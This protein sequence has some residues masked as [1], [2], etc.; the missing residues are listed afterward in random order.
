MKKITQNSF[1]KGMNM[2]LNPLSTPKDV[3]TDCLNGT[4]ITYNGD[5]FNLQTELG[6]VQVRVTGA[7]TEDPDALPQGF[8]PLGI[9]EYNGIMYIVAHNPF[10][11]E[12]RVGS[13]PSP[14]R[15]V[16]VSDGDNL[17][18]KTIADLW[19]D[20][21]GLKQSISINHGM[22]LL[23]SFITSG[24]KFRIAL[25]LDGLTWA[26]A[27]ELLT[28]FVN[29]YAP[30]SV[31]GKDRGTGYFNFNYYVMDIDGNL[32]PIPLSL[33]PNFTGD[34]SDIDFTPSPGL[35]GINGV[36]KV[37]KD[38]AKAVIVVIMTPCTL[39]AFDFTLAGDNTGNILKSKIIF[40]K[41]SII[42]N[43]AI[44]VKTIKIK[45]TSSEGTTIADKYFDYEAYQNGT[46]EVIITK[47]DVPNTAVSFTA[48]TVLT[49]TCTPIDQ[50]G[51]ELIDLTVTKT[52]EISSLPLGIDA[53]SH[54]TYVLND[55]DTITIKYNFLYKG[56]VGIVNTNIEFYDFW[57]NIST[58]KMDIPIVDGECSVTL[59]LSA[60][61]AS[62]IFDGTTQGGYPTSGIET[63]VSTQKIMAS[64]NRKTRTTILRKNH[65]YL[66]R[67]FG[68]ETV[69]YNIFQLLYTLPIPKF[70][71]TNAKNFGSI[72]IVQGLLQNGNYD[73]DFVGT[74]LADSTQ[75]L[76]TLTNTPV[77]TANT[78]NYNPIS[79]DPTDAYRLYGGP[80]FNEYY[81]PSTEAL[82]K[83]NW[84]YVDSYYRNPYDG[85]FYNGLDSVITNIGYHNFSEISM[86][87]GFTNSNVTF[88]PTLFPAGNAYLS[89]PLSTGGSPK[90]FKF[91]L[92]S[93]C[94]IT[95]ANQTG[96]IKLIPYSK[97]N[98][99]T[100]LLFGEV[101]HTLFKKSIQ[102]KGN[103]INFT[104]NIFDKDFTY[105]NF[106]DI[107]TN[108]TWL[109]GGVDN[110]ASTSAT[111]KASLTTTDILDTVTLSNITLASQR[112]TTAPSLFSSYN[113]TFARN[114]NFRYFT[115][116]SAQTAKS[117]RYNANSYA[118]LSDYTDFK[119]V[120][121]DDNARS[122]TIIVPPT[123]SL[124]N[125]IV[126]YACTL[127]IDINL[128]LELSDIYSTDL[129]YTAIQNIGVL[130]DQI[131]GNKISEVRTGVTFTPTQFVIGCNSSSAG[132]NVLQ[133]IYQVYKTNTPIYVDLLV[134]DPAIALNV[135]NQLWLSDLVTRPYIGMVG[136][137]YLD[138]LC[139]YQSY[140][141][142]ILAQYADSANIDY[143]STGT[144]TLD[145]TANNVIYN[146]NTPV[147]DKSLR[148]LTKTC[149]GSA[150]LMPFTLKSMDDIITNWKSNNASFQILYNFAKV[151]GGD[152]NIPW[153]YISLPI[154]T[155]PLRNTRIQLNAGSPVAMQNIFTNSKT[156]LEASTP[157]IS[158]TG[159]TPV[160][161]SVLSGDLYTVQTT[162]PYFSLIDSNAS[163]NINN[164][165]LKIPV[166]NTTTLAGRI[167]Q[168]ENAYGIDKYLVDPPSIT[169]IT[170]GRTYTV[171]ERFGGGIIFYVDGTGKHGLIVAK[172][173]CSVGIFWARN[174]GCTCGATY[175]TGASGT[176][177]GTGY[178]NTNIISANCCASPYAVST[179]LS[180]S[181]NGYI[182]W[183]FPSVSEMQRMYTAGMLSKGIGISTSQDYWTSSESTGGTSDHY[184]F[185]YNF[186]SN[187]SAAVLKNN[188]RRVRAIRK[189]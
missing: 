75:G 106:P 179:C 22:N 91:K 35:G 139:V 55:N 33:S 159:I 15:Y 141:E 83:T 125:K 109:K 100:P 23:T 57:S 32:T 156:R 166:I 115:W 163:N 37:Y 11:K 27:H 169:E 181:S 30:T 48:G 26:H 74:Q 131:T 129:I 144:D 158:Q 173:D 80:V 52:Y 63:S 170:N 38:D 111:V 171:G 71:N 149:F 34:Y 142:T 155:V 85:L 31:N 82:K 120:G 8:I 87:L 189:F 64:G 103:L 143:V 92:L 51:R 24:D 3:L 96:T 172:E 128:S 165:V 93:N 6:N 145:L 118:T 101:D 44:K 148:Y 70:V 16:V 81:K 113:K 123:G 59:S 68:T 13:L 46:M 76:L 21:A 97:V 132:N 122:F 84:S 164:T 89:T 98:S 41:S 135:Y 78:T 114:K 61:P 140:K 176:V 9:K 90:D 62:K 42:E 133:T 56:Q 187:T 108:F 65:C 147:I 161:K 99:G 77:F 45:T 180:Y 10:T 29:N 105:S 73:L 54:F 58:L 69:D 28:K 25:T 47:E 20:S 183:F 18:T 160:I 157:L 188:D 36:Y 168:T 174:S 1:G 19:G 86:K 94:N 162:N 7:D 5:E 50:F 184:A 17:T 186:G 185:M 167:M 67:I 126:T 178:T 121:G 119:L 2:D 39:E 107:V 79:G 117:K 146:T 72:D 53:H 138:D 43:S 136:S 49:V 88:S 112:L 12:T 95:T 134:S 153:N 124:V 154:C 14:Q 4:I 116:E 66:I 40:N 137:T 175:T 104:T 182:D 60:A 152:R 102:I 177:I 130:V 150:T 127:G 110:T 151:D